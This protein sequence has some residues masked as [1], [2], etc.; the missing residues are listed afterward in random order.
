MQRK[1]QQE[2][3]GTTVSKVLG[4][5]SAFEKLMVGPC[6]VTPSK[7]LGG[8]SSHLNFMG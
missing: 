7:D 6:R 2:K 8:G 1:C 5:G 4:G 3:V